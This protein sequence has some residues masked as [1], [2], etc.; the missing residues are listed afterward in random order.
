MRKEL[1]KSLKLTLAFCLLLSVGYVGVLWAFAFI[2]TPGKGSVETVS[3]NGKEVGAA[4]VGQSFTHN[5]LFWGR[6]SAVN[7]AADASSGSNFGPSNPVYL[8][9]VEDRVTIFLKAHPYLTRREV[10]S[11]MVTASG[12]GL[13]PHISVKAALVQVK[14]VASAR[15]LPVEKVRRIVDSL[16]EKP[17]MG[18]VVINVLKLNVALE[19][20]AE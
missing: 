7:Y 11:E 5:D 20:M 18:P 13:D 3:L 8:K 1:L 9:I 19:E 12:S 10:P 17:L 14:R 2:C 15:K 6:P 16:Q 4:Y